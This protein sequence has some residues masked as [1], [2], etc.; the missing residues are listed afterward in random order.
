MV[1]VVHHGQTIHSPLKQGLAFAARP[2]YCY[3]PRSDKAIAGLTSTA[4]DG[5]G[6]EN[7]A[8]W[9][10]SVGPFARAAAL[11][12]RFDS[13]AGKRRIETARKALE[14]GAIRVA[15][16]DSLC[17][18]PKNR[19]QAGVAAAGAESPLGPADTAE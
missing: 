17:R 3:R 13:R 6:I 2:T 10:A 19:P 8:S 12:H 4:V 9:P 16:T 1:L 7:V 18:L 15:R 11:D 5:R 14:V